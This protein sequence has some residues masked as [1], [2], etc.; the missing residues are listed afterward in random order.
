MVYELVLEYH[1]SSFVAW[2]CNSYVQLGSNQTFA[3]F[4]MKKT[5][6]AV[7][8]LVTL[9]GASLFA[10]T[11]IQTVMGYGAY[12]TGSGGEFTFKTT[13][14]T[15]N[16]I[17]GGYYSGAKNQDTTVA[18]QP[19]FQTFCVEGGEFVNKNHSYDVVFNDHSVFSGN[20]LTKG[21]ALLYSSFASGV[22]GGILPP[23]YNYA[24]GGP[25][26]AGFRY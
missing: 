3:D 15:M 24:G 7:L 2:H 23:G 8:A 25:G 18:D 14:P 10:N 20:Y 13:D 21:A 9:T 5:F 16:A 26:G 12:Q 6:L 17:V 11:T 4:M 22:W 1:R 19:N